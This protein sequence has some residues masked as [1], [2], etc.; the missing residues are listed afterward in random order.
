MA[1]DLTTMTLSVADALDGATATATVSGAGAGASVALLRAPWNHQAGG[2]MDWTEAGTGT[3]DGSGNC[4]VVTTQAPGFYVWQAVRMATASTADRLTRGVFRPVVDPADPI[5]KQILDAAVTLIRSLNL[6]GI[7][8]DAS[9]VF[10][11]WFPIYLLDAD[12]ATGGG[13][14]LPMCQVAPYGKEMPLD[15]MSNRDDVG[16]PVMVGF[17][18]TV[19]PTLDSNMSRNLKWRRQVAAAFRAQQLAGAPNVVMTTWQPDSIAVVEGLRMN[20]HVGAVNLM[21]RSRESRGLIA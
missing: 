15:V 9:K 10:A 19:E 14:G 17:F 3:A 6:D 21:F 2:G 5:H 11:R 1:L 16:Y 8:S 18:D 12:K 7:G 13:G 20:Y 4:T